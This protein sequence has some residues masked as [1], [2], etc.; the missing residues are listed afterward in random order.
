MCFH[1]KETHFAFAWSMTKLYKPEKGIPLDSY[2][3][4]EF[5]EFIDLKLLTDEFPG[6]SMFE[7]PRLKYWSAGNE[8]GG[9]PLFRAF[10]RGSKK[11]ACKKVI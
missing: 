10:L 9:Q 5:I 11:A 1:L 3:V 7:F 2:E 4:W 8:L 6:L